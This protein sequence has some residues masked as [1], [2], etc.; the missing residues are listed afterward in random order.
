MSDTQNTN[1]TVNPAGTPDTPNASGAQN[2]A[3]PAPPTRR[4][5]IQNVYLGIGL[6]TVGAALLCVGLSWILL[7]AR[8]SSFFNNPGYRPLQVEQESTL[9]APL[10]LA[11]RLD[12]FAQC[13]IEGPKRLPLP[14]ELSKKEILQKTRELWEQHLGELVDLSGQD[15]L[16]KIVSA[17]KASAVLRDFYNESTGARLSLWCTQV[18]YDTG[19]VTLCLSLQLDSRTGEPLYLSAAFYSSKGDAPTAGMEIFAKALGYE[20]TE[21]MLSQLSTATTET[22][23]TATLPLG[24]GLKLEKTCENGVQYTLRVCVEEELE[25]L[26]LE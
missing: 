7:G 5:K 18:W 4:E 13:E 20:L 8:R 22:G 9:G 17:S 26:E 3:T 2:A 1:N 6:G 24:D 10:S 11:T 12:L 25:A 23:Y 19:S 14:E 16:N 15:A 21:E